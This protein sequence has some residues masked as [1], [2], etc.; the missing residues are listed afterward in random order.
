MTGPDEPV[1]GD[2]DRVIVD[3][4]EYRFAP[5]RDLN[6]AELEG[7]LADRYGTCKLGSNC[8]CLKAECPWLGRGCLNWVPLGVKTWA[9][10]EA[11]IKKAVTE[12]RGK[13]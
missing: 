12:Q 10:L 3:G 7:Y 13:T 9:E 6:P 2:P 5:A 11:V 1:Q 4:V 8:I